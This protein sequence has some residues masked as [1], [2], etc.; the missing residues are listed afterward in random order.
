M[1]AIKVGRQNVLD[2]DDYHALMMDN[3][4]EVTDKRLISLREIEE[5]TGT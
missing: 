3:I 2:V 1:N 4:D 5:K